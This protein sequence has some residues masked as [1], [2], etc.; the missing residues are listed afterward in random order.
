MCCHELRTGAE[1]Q[2]AT[3]LW[4]HLV[5]PNKHIA[6]RE[7]L[8]VC[9]PSSMLFGH[10]KKQ[11]LI[12]K[13]HHV[14]KTNKHQLAHEYREHLTHER[15]AITICKNSQ[16]VMETHMNYKWIGFEWHSRNTPAMSQAKSFMHNKRVQAMY[17]KRV[18]FSNTQRHC[19]RAQQRIGPEVLRC[20]SHT[21]GGGTKPLGLKAQLAH[22][23]QGFS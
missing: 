17:Q 23:K 12:H 13:A 15:I 3:A 20:N 1:E 14:A 21:R 4:H 10:A 11:S 7:R 19:T 5:A 9:S 18:Q 16:E 8:P 6:N 22:A 2:Q